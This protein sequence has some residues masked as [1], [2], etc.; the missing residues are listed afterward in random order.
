VRRYTFS[1]GFLLWSALLLC[2]PR[3]VSQDWN[4]VKG[5][6]VGDLAERAVSLPDR[7]EIVVANRGSCNL[8]V[9]ST[10]TNEVITTM[11][12]CM[13]SRRIVL[14]RLAHCPEV[15]AA[16]TRLGSSIPTTIR[17][18]PGQAFPDGVGKIW[19]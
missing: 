15:M 7:N 8:S 13:S 19:R 1:V 6:K 2:A 3:L 17:W 16:I 11:V 12:T 5:I 10:L 9:I 14:H 4:F 18:N